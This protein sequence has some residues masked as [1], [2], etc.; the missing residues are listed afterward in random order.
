MILIAELCQNHNGDFDLLKKMVYSA[1]E[2]GADFV[3][4]Q[5]IFADMLA[6]RERFEEGI[7]EGGVTK[8]IKRPYKEEYDRLKK[9]ELTFKQQKEFIRICHE[10]DIK[11]LTTAFT[12]DSIDK[13]IEIG[14]EDVKIASYD[15]SSVPLLERLKGNFDNIFLSTGATYDDEI[16][17]AAKVLEGL[18][19]FLLHCVTIYPT[20]LN[21]FNLSR[22]QFLKKYTSKVGWSDHSLVKR[23]G[24]KGTIAAIYYGAQ[25]IE[26]HYTIQGPEMSKDG[27]VSIGPDEL[28]ELKLISLLSKPEL[29]NYLEDK[30]PDFSET[31][32]SSDRILSKLEL[33]NR[34]YFRGRFANIDVSGNIVYNWEYK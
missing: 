25:V 16:K 31:F 2:S 7:V 15:C 26:R 12:C 23:D 28:K 6:F 33:L 3:K 22:M 21:Q 11:P 30:Y 9:L 13:I 32:G 8:S 17:M 18:N 27:P 1:K 24:I 20:P 14:F 34:D 5:T 4:I 29:E 10:L 19:F